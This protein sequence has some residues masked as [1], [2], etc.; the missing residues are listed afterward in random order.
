ME[1][2]NNVTKDT[3][4]HMLSKSITFNGLVTQSKY[5]SSPSGFNPT[6]ERDL[7]FIRRV[8]PKYIGR[9]AFFWSY[10]EN[11]DTVEYIRY[12]TEGA[13]RIHEI[14]EE[15][16]LEAAVFETCYESFV[17]TVEIPKYV[18]D[19]FQQPFEQRNFSYENIKHINGPY[20]SDN[21]WDIAEKS[22]VPDITRIE[23]KMWFYYWGT[24]YIDAGYDSI[25][26]G[27][28]ML[29]GANDIST[30]M[31]KNFSNFREVFSKIREYAKENGRNRNV[32]ISSHSCS[33]EFVAYSDDNPMANKNEEYKLI[34]DFHTYPIRLD[35][36]GMKI[37]E[38]G[39]LPAKVT[40]G[41]SDSIYGRGAGG[42][43]PAGFYVDEN[44]YIVEFDNC[45]IWEDVPA[46]NI[47][48]VPWGRDESSWLATLPKGTHGEVIKEIRSQV[49]AVSEGKGFLMLPCHQPIARCINGRDFVKPYSKDG[50]YYLGL[51]YEETICE[52]LCETGETCK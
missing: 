29:I 8:K 38:N 2:S 35:D 12:I 1:N 50:K 7:E 52:M 31:T 23:T 39:Y 41:Y 28:T 17:D 37:Q 5:F 48:G 13:A 44:F 47:Y 26:M 9:A 45:N 6:F 18:F 32:F 43:N 51:D 27:Q 49:L 10:P 36:A 4:I 11:N 46:H 30:D 22:A 24:V 33:S 21:H 16:V 19:A 3:L 20:A 42:M 14:S 40:K 34:Y 25:H 15:I